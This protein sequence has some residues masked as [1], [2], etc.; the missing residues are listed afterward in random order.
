MSD[1]KNTFSAGVND[2]LDTDD[3]QRSLEEIIDVDDDLGLE[4]ESNFAIDEESEKEKDGVSYGEKIILKP[5][6][7]PTETMVGGL[8]DDQFIANVKVQ[9]DTRDP[10]FQI[11]GPVH[12]QTGAQ[13]RPSDDFDDYEGFTA[14]RLYVL[15]GM[16]KDLSGPWNAY[17]SE[18]RVLTQERTDQMPD[19]VKRKFIWWL[20]THHRDTPNSNGQ[21]RYGDKIQMCSHWYRKAD[22]KRLVYVPGNKGV[23]YLTP[24]SEARTL[25]YPYTFKIQRAL[26]QQD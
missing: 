14:F 9:P 5:W 22:L 15:T 10:R 8:G 7:W 19:S 25:H 17:D 26:K 16:K 4:P 20:P 13:V 2:P 18:R 23:T 12:H 1:R 6:D 24:I 11:V 21:L 3:G